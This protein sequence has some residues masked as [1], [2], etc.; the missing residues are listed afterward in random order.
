MGALPDQRLGFLLIGTGLTWFQIDQIAP[1]SSEETPYPDT[2]T[3]SGS[4]DNRIPG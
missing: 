2:V 3:H 4:S 1:W